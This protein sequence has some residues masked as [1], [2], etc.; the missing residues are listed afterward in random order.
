MLRAG[1][2]GSFSCAAGRG[3]DALKHG[4]R[5]PATPA[6]P[7][8]GTG[9][10]TVQQPPLSPRELSWENAASSGGRDPS[11]WGP[12]G[13]GCP[14]SPQTCQCVPMALPQSAQWDFSAMPSPSLL[15]VPRSQVRTRPLFA[16][17]KINHFG[18]EFHASEQCQGL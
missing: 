12:T 11:S 15:A 10:P 9:T 3:M 7:L 2:G 5:D 1:V 8:G 4:P 14:R 13:Q 16:F 18:G 6:Q 17:F